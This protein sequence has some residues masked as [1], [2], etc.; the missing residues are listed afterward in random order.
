[1]PLQIKNSNPSMRKSKPDQILPGNV[2]YKR[3][4]RSSRPFIFQ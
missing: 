4:N 3:P 1:M 2:H